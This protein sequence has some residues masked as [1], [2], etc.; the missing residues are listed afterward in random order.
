MKI[1]SIINKFLRSAFSLK[2]TCNI[3]GKE[4]FNDSYYCTDCKSKL[5][6]ITSIKCDH[7]GRLTSNPTLFCESC[8]GKNENIDTARSVYSYNEAIAKII[9]NFK[10]S[11][12]TY[13]K[14]IFSEEL[15]R[16]YLNNFWV[17]DY[18][19]Y[20]PM[21]K[22]RLLDRG[23]NQSKLMAEGLSEILKVPT[24]E[25]VEKVCETDRQATLTASQRKDNLKGSFKGKKI[26][27]KGKTITVIDDVLTT[28]VTMDLVAK[29]LKKMGASKVYALTVASVG[30]KINDI[31]D[32]N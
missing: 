8:S 18:L 24:V 28:G 9:Y 27:L 13:I 19:T 29:E 2:W 21:S 3:C 5:I 31:N 1:K 25:L 6:P 22:E 11:S 12:K 15:S 30:K 32:E 10:Y 4:I 20:I 26:D 7:C 16:V 14:D 17:S 23:Y